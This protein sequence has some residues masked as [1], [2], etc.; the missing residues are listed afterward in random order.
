MKDFGIPRK[1]QK[2][3]GSNDKEQIWIYFVKFKAKITIHVEGA[4][5]IHIFFKILQMNL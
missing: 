5:K 2:H 1:C 3:T 4:K